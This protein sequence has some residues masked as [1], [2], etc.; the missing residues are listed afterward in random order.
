VD[1]L[2]ELSLD[3]DVRSPD[4]IATEYANQ[5]SPSTFYSVAAN[6]AGVS[7]TPTDVTSGSTVSSP[8]IN[9]SYNL[10]PTSITSGVSFSTVTAGSA[11]G[12]TPT[13]VTSGS[14]VSSPVL[15]TNYSLT[16]TD[17][18]SGVTFVSPVISTKAT[19]EG[20]TSYS[21]G[22]NLSVTFYLSPQGDYKL[23]N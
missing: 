20:L 19:I 21:L 6:D 5:N 23:I 2:D 13:D 12:L 7:L 11:T 3:N 16:A 9:T 4:W 22:A 17:V 8:T 15:N 1:N 18:T 10:T 14:V